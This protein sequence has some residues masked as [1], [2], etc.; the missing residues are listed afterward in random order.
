MK[1]ET[2]RDVALSGE[3]LYNYLRRLVNQFFKIL[4]IRE[5]EEDTV[6]TY[7][8]SLQVELLGCDA[9]ICS[10][11]EDASFLSLLSILQYLIDHPVSS[12]AVYKREVFKAISLCNK[13]K[14]L[15]A[16]APKGG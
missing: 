15:Y 1:I 16:E 2:T 11:H 3:I 4:P 10:L 14:A 12:I 13:L 8:E 9:L 6:V 7:M 5:N